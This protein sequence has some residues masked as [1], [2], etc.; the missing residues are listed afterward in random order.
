MVEIVTNEMGKLK[1]SADFLQIHTM[2]FV[3]LK[4]CKV[5]LYIGV[6]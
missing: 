1:K 3:G 6:M 5:L 2:I 4:E